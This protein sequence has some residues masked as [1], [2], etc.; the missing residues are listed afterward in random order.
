MFNKLLK[1]Y[2]RLGA[3][4]LALAG[5]AG[6]AQQATVNLGATVTGNQEQPKV[7]YIVPWQAPQGPI[8]FS[9]GFNNQ[10]EQ[11]FSHVERVE[12]QRELHYRQQLSQQPLML[13][14][15]TATQKQGK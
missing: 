14:L 1:W 11:V 5:N 7:L 2:L 10:L 13:Q 15:Q 8:E 12:L 4:A 6:W 3:L 9:Q